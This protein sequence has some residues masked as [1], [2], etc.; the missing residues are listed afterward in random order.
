MK[1]WSRTSSS[2]MKLEGYIPLVH[3]Q[4]ICQF[5][6]DKNAENGKAGYFTFEYNSPFYEHLGED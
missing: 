4:Y 3:M 5:R 6:V 2:T 1:D